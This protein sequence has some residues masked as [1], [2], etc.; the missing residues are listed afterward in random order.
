MR[1]PDGNT[2]ALEAYL[3]EQDALED[4]DGEEEEEP[5]PFGRDYYLM[6]MESRKGEMACL[7]KP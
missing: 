2:A 3:R 5:E 7:R 1:M 6:L 4:D